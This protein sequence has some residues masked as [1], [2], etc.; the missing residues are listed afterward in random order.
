LQLTN[1]SNKQINKINSDAFHASLATVTGEMI[2]TNESGS[3][4]TEI[5]PR[6]FD[7]NLETLEND[8]SESSSVGLPKANLNA[9]NGIPNSCEH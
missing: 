2:E 7:G 5:D 4:E 9:S 1:D 6:K 8:L 3:S